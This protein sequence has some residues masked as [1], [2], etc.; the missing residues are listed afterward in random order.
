VYPLKEGCRRALEITTTY[1]ERSAMMQPKSVFPWWGIPVLAFLSLGAG[2]SG[3]ALIDG[4]KAGDAGVVRALLKQKGDANTA[5]ADGTTALH[6]AVN[7]SD[8]EMVGLLLSAGA[9]PRTANRYGVMPIHLAGTIGNAPVVEKLLKA[10]ADANAALP[11]GETPL[12]AAARSGNVETVKLLLEHGADVNATEGWKGQSALMWAAAENHADV[13]RALVKAGA[14]IRARSKGGVF[15][16]FLFAVRAGQID[17]ARALIESGQ[18]V[19]QTLPDG[20]S[21][22]VLAVTNAHWEMAA[23]LL[24]NG[25]DPNAAAQ[26]W[27][28]LHQISW[29]RRPNYGYNLPGPVPTGKL[30]A[31]DLVKELVRHGA[32]VNA[33]ETKEPR[34]GNRNMLNRI[35]ATPFLL[36]A[37]AVDLPLM[38]TLLEQG[39]DPKLGNVDG[40]TPLMVAAGVGIWAPGESPG[41]EE[42]ALAAV[43]MLLDI[44]AGSAADVDKNGY[45]ALHGAI[46]RAGSIPILRLLVEKGA[47]L[48][49]RNSKGWLPLT[50]AEGIEYTQ[51][52]FKRY[53]E[54][55]E[56]LRQLMR[57][58]GIPV[59][60]PSE[61][62]AHAIDTGRADDSRR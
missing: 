21:A 4:V 1:H 12:M 36:A 56:V 54:T 28:A 18:D 59:P 32:D 13:V 57:E 60:P 23:V 49:A 34:D 25:A 3:P 10:G 47:K 42:E 26:G 53:P 52:I 46:H 48:D 58:Q 61:G 2:G 6:W 31:L 24:E 30:D 38:R 20:T 7:R 16:P 55:A 44:G 8:V 15:T 33:R 50:I 37:K 11:E 41:T 39:A 29:T 17:A 35:G 27:T 5:E 40:T 43:K 19:N 51:D 45:T 62:V 22:L 9:N 14:D